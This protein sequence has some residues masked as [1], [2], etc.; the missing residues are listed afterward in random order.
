MPSTEIVLS[1]CNDS[2]VV[3]ELRARSADASLELIS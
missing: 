2:D 1:A 3:E